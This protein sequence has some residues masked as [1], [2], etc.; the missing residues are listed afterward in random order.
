MIDYELQFEVDSVKRQG[1][2][3]DNPESPVDGKS[4]TVD[5]ADSGYI[6][7]CGGFMGNE[8]LMQQHYVSS[9]DDA[10]NWLHSHGCTRILN[11]CQ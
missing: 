9:I 3:L 5:Y 2:P 6:A 7:I 8:S 4:G 1:L 10:I 11:L